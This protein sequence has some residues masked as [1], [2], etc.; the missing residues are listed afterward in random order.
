MGEPLA[1]HEEGSSALLVEN[2]MIGDSQG[3]LK[4]DCRRTTDGLQDDPGLGWRKKR[5]YR[6]SVS[7]CC[8]R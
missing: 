3:D 4:W 7:G 5:R 8:E 1:I 6:L 2:R